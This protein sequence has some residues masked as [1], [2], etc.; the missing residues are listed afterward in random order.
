VKAKAN[1]LSGF[2][3]EKS[4]R[5]LQTALTNGR[6]SDHEGAIFDSSSNIGEFPGILQ[7][8]CP[9]H[10]RTSLTKGKTVRVDQAKIAHPEVTHRARRRTNIQRIARAYEHDNQLVEFREELQAFNFT[11][12]RMLADGTE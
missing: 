9:S 4:W 12:M 1:R 10:G 2:F 5:T 7:Q 11:T 8:N 3:T 6:R